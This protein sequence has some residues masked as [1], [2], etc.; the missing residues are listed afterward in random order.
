GAGGAWLMA[1]VTGTPQHASTVALIGLVSTQLAQTLVD[2]RSPLVVVTALGS[3]AML[4]GIISTPGLSQVFGCTPVGP[5]GWSQAF[6]ATAGA[7]ILST[8]APALL[9]RATDAIRTR[10]ADLVDDR[11]SKGDNTRPAP[12]SQ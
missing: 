5:L 12:L 8:T 11:M 10:V 4:T 9:G 6:S 1:S 3:F 7:T 2:S